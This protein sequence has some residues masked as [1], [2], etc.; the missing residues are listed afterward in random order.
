MRCSEI[1]WAGTASALTF[2]LARNL[3]STLSVSRAVKTIG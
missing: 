2:P 1:L 3:L